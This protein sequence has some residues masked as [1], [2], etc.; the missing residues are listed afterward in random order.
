MALTAESLLPWLTLRLPAYIAA[1]E[2][3]CAIDSPTG[4]RPGIDAM[5]QWA[6]QW[7]AARGWNIRR[8]PD[9]RAGDG[10]AL[11][12]HGTGRLRVLLAAHMDTVYPLGTAAA[13]PLRREGERLVGPGSAD[14]KSG[15]L[16]AL[17]VA[18]ALAALAPQSF[19]TLSVVC[20]S[21]EERDSRASRA[22]LEALAPAYEL[23]LVMEPARANGDIVSARKGSGVFVLDVTGRAAHAGVEPERGVNAIVALAHQIVALQALNGLRPGVTV[24][25]GVIAGGEA[26]NVVPA[27]ARALVDVRAARPEDMA[28]VTAAVEAIAAREVVA[29][30][31]TQVSGGWTF[32]PM[33]RTPAIER[34]A[35]LARADLR[36]TMGIDAE[37][38]FT[39]I[40]RW[41]RAMPQYLPGHLERLE[42]IEAGLRALPNVALA[43]AGYRGI[44]IP[45]C[46]RQGTQAACRLI[47]ALVA[48]E[49]S[50]PGT[51]QTM[52]VRRR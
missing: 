14:N 16:S 15:L 28:P 31:V 39:R 9:D 50:P 32:A 43:G 17:Y 3:L 4:H 12:V 41:A 18:E 27:Q 2:Q 19:G 11:T 20:G 48:L 21:D 10:L 51:G 47:E 1:L 25:V 33:A 52:P 7:A 6:E 38:V 49:P 24:N 45:D 5:G 35:D 34:L 36:A 8:F 26:P 22:M 46:V 23:A 42:A 29:G 30:A 13:R 37:P 40:A 44:G